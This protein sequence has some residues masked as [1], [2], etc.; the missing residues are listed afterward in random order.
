MW[1][2]DNDLERVAACPGCGDSAT[3]TCLTSN[4]YSIQR[5]R[6]CNLMFVNPRP[7][8]DSIRKLFEDEYIC[9]EQRVQSDFT[10]FRSSSLRREAEIVKRLFPHGGT[11]L[12]VGTASGAFLGEFAGAPE[13]RVEGLE[14]SKFAASAASR[15]YSVPVYTGFLDT[16]TLA[17]DRYDVVT[18]LD[19]F[20]FHSNPN[21]DLEIIRGLLKKD[22]A[23]VVEIPGRK[24]RLLK[25]SGYLCRLLYGVDAR[26]NAGVHLFYYDRQSLKRLMNR[27]GFIEVAA[28][29]EQS[30]VYGSV[31][32]RLVNTGYFS[33]T[34]ALYWVT[35][36]VINYAPKEVMIYN[37][38]N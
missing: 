17:K 25:N 6:S 16:V 33:L 4:G 21:R 36:G 15:K 37:K 11:L 18:T 23:L 5:C 3:A 35:K 9:D 22:G 27:H 14:P 26:L 29:P 38:V 28:Y 12:D 2:K 20:Y 7:S 34:S 1:E 13:W 31:L 30:P 10:S 24:F 19:A 8:E 32:R